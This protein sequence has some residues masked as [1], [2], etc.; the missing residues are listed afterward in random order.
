VNFFKPRSAPFLVPT[1]TTRPHQ[2]SR[3]QNNQLEP[4]QHDEQVV[5]QYVLVMFQITDILL[6]YVHISR[7][8]PFQHSFRS[9]ITLS[10]IEAG[11][12]SLGM[13]LARTTPIVRTSMSR[14]DCSRRACSRPVPVAARANPCSC[15]ATAQ[16]KMSILWLR[17]WFVMVGCKLSW[18][19]CTPALW[20]SPRRGALKGGGE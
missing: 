5:L 17:Y 15:V 9:E 4:Q 7:E 13:V 18:R 8:P 10:T 14:G 6:Q 20:L 3:Q 12:Q 19:Y 2:E 16:A 11:V 1:L